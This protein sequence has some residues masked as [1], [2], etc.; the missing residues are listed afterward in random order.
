MQ[1]EHF[2]ANVTHP[3]G[4]KLVAIRISACITPRSE[5]GTPRGVS[6]G[7]S[8]PASELSQI[9]EDREEVDQQHSGSG[10]RG[11]TRG[12]GQRSIPFLTT[13]PV[14][15]PVSEAREL[16]ISYHL[17]QVQRLWQNLKPL[18]S[19]TCLE[20]RLPVLVVLLSTEYG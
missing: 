16:L 9:R 7:P 12:F 3:Q 13:L 5:E 6:Q 15:P 11:E 19:P 4:V 10:E 17:H 14:S 18:R 1:P 2:R 8:A 20:D